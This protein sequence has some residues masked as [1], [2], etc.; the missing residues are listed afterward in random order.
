MHAVITFNI[1]LTWLEL[2]SILGHQLGLL[3]RGPKG[4]A[5]ERPCDGH[6]K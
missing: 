3:Q 1:N 2:L 4:S 6:E 5:E